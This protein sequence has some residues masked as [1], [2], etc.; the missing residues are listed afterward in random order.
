[1]F[2]ALPWVLGFEAVW[3]PAAA[4]P[5]GALVGAVTLRYALD[6]EDRRALAGLVRG[7]GRA[8]RLVRR[9]IQGVT[10]PGR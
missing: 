3:I 10:I 7:D 8:A 9:A 4:I 1:M 6:D 5:S 2:A